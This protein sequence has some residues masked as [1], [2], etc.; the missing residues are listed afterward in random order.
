MVLR[1]SMATWRG[2]TVALLLPR[3][4]AMDDDDGYSVMS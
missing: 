1:D 3:C 4:P 2:V